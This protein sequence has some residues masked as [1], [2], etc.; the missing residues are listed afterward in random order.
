MFG[1]NKK[2]GLYLKEKRVKASLNQGEVAEALGYTTPQFVSN[3]ERGLS[4]PPPNKYLAL[5]KLYKIDR[6]EFVKVLLSLEED[7]LCALL[8]TKDTKRKRA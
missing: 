6:K 4:S 1:D 7:A 5:V 3:W 2:F 8:K